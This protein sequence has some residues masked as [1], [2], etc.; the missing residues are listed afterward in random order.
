VDY[1]HL[2]DAD[3]GALVAFVK[4]R[5][6]VD[7]APPPVTVGPVGRGLFLA[8]KLPILTA[9]RIDHS[10][11]SSMAVVPGPTADYGRYVAA[12]GCQGCHGV[13]LAGGPIG[14]VRDG[15]LIEI[16]IDTRTLEGRLNLVGEAGADA[17][18]EEGTRI[19]ERR[20]AR[21]DLAPDP[22]LPDDTRIWAA[23]Q[24]VSGGPWGGSASPLGRPRPPR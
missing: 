2:T 15:D 17:G 24:D 1:V 9:E 4:S 5:P 20:G 19:L 10:R 11:S 12:I 6:P 13:T 23:L 14:R 22:N 3:L 21:P 7:T 18:V 16:V 8:G